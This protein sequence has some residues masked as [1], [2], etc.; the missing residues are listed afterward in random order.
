MNHENFRL[1]NGECHKKFL[2]LKIKTLTTLKLYSNNVAVTTI[3]LGIRIFH[4]EKSFYVAL[5]FEH[6]YDYKKS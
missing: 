1:I 2:Q 6:V 5:F 3:H 4:C